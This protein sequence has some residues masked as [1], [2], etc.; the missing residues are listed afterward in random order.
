MSLNFQSRSK[1]NILIKTIS[2]SIDIE[3][4]TTFNLDPSTS[5]H[6]TGISAVW[7]LN[8]LQIMKSSISKAHLSKWRVSKSLLAD[9]FV[10]SLNP[11]WVSFVLIPQIIVMRN[12]KT[13]A[14]N[15]LINFL[16][17]LF[18]SLKWCLEPTTMIKGW[19]NSACNYSIFFFTLSNSEKVVA[20][21]ASTISWYFPVATDI[22]HL[23]APP[24]PRFLGY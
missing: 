1:Y 6:Y 4:S 11:H 12:L 17:T 2:L 21:S 14:M 15:F 3:A 24:F 20:P 10:K 8:L 7:Y 19:W 18:Y 9:S 5:L 13:P 23:T 22:P 16:S